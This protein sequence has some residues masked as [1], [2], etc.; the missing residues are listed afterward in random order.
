MNETAIRFE[1]FY[2]GYINGN[3][4]L[5]NVNVDIGKG[6]FTVISGPSGAGKT[7]LCKAMII[8]L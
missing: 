5:H 8:V 2:Y 7:T 1:N 3:V 6:S 4:V